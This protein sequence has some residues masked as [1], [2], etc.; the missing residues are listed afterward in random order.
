MP[1]KLEVEGLDSFGDG[2]ETLEVSEFRQHVPGFLEVVN[3]C[4]LPE[5]PVAVCASRSS[6]CLVR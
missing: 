2:T 3:R 6:A 5:Y 4:H 1:V